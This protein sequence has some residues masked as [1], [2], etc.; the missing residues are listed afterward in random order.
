[1]RKATKNASVTG[2]APKARATTMSRTK[3]STRLASVAS[4]M[5]PTALTTPRWTCSWASRRRSPGDI[6]LDSRGAWTVASCVAH[7]ASQPQEEGP[8]A[9]TRSAKKRIKQ[10][11]KR[12]LRNRAVRS[13]IRSAGED[14]RATR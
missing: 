8:V 2:P 4:P 1:M 10:N 5:T 9:N 13:A 6:I 11:E 14:A 3:P 7:A 12:R